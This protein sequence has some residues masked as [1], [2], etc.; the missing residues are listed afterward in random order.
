MRAP[1]LLS[2]IVVSTGLFAATLSEAVQFTCGDVQDPPGISAS[3]AL[4]TLQTAVNLR[5]CSLCA[6]DANASLSI[7][8]SDALL[9]L[10][11]AVAQPVSLACPFCCEQCDCTPQ[12]LE[13]TLTDVAPCEGCI[14]RV[15]AS[16]TTVDGITIEFVENLNAAYSLRAV[17]ECVWEATL[18]GGIVQKTF[19]GNETCSGPASPQ[20]QTDVVLRVSRTATGWEV[21]AGQYPVSLG[22]G[23]VVR[24]TIES[25][26][27]DV[28][29]AA[30]NANEV[31]E[32]AEVGAPADYDVHAIGGST[33]LEITDTQPVCP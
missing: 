29:D 9:V 15:P 25:A 2:I 12:T 13:L 6:C 19:L 17:A 21:H 10:K 7:T 20:G 26:S 16:N 30:P 5:E 32:L 11:K 8:A 4:A 1:A 27:C 3:D 28:G 24:S 23:D 14:P 31:C 22:W 33:V 18:P